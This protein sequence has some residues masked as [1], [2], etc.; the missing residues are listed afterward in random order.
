MRHYL[1]TIV[2]VFILSLNISHALEPPKLAITTSGLAANLSWPMVESA[3]AYTLYYAPYP[4]QGATTI[5]S[6]ELGDKSDL[7]VTLWDGAAFYIVVTAKNKTDT[8]AYS[9]IELLAINQSNCVDLSGNWKLTLAVDCGT[10]Q[11]LKVID[12]GTI[13][14]N[15]CQLSFAGQE[16]SSFQGSIEADQVQF[17]AT[18][19]YLGIA[20]DGDGELLLGDNGQLKG[21]AETTI[22]VPNCDSTAVIE[23]VRIN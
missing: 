12:S 21:T 8:S 6:I 17:S 14:Q 11:P 22:S 16:G 13:T 19:L 23:G 4:Y 18:F 9:N 7:D 3:T 20:I 15:N 5:K 1:L 2:A 10:P